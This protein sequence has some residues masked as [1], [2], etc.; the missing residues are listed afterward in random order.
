MVVLVE[1]ELRIDCSAA[2]AAE[3]FDT[4]GNTCDGWLRIDL[5]ITEASR[6]LLVEVKDPF[7]SRA[8]AD[9]QS[10]FLVRLK[11]KEL[12][13]DLARK[14]RDSYCHCHLMRLDD[15]PMDYVIL[16][17]GATG[18]LIPGELMALRDNVAKRLKREGTQPWRRQYIRDC[19]IVDLDGWSKVFPHYPV[20]RQP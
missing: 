10:R 17:A 12:V 20:T 18:K 2:E 16:I 4:P 11:T 9:E 6:R 15:L 8:T 14:A 13:P 1:G 7:C 3:V 5:L 19:S